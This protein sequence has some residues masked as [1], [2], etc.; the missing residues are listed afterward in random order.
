MPPVMNSF[1]NPEELETVGVYTERGEKAR[2]FMMQFLTPIMKNFK[3]EGLENLEPVEHLLGKFPITLISN[4]LSHLDAPGI[5]QLLYSSGPLGKKIAENMVF[6]AGRLAFEPDFTRLGLYMFGTLLVCSKKDMSDNPSLSCRS[7]T[8]T[9]L[10][11]TNLPLAGVNK[12]PEV[13]RI[14]SVPSRDIG[15]TILF[16]T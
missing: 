16:A 8:M 11:I 7:P 1:K 12:N 9:G 14:L 5:F 15:K 3:V 13:G 4:H 6:I 10:P 2:D